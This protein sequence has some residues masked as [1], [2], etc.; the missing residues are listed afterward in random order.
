MC[1]STYFQSFDQ[2]KRVYKEVEKVKRKVNID[3]LVGIEARN[4]KELEILASMRRKFDILLVRGGDLRLN[5]LAC[6]TPEVDILTHPELK[7][8][9][10]GLN[11]VLVKFAAKNKVAIEI[12]FREILITSKRTRAKLIS[13]IANNVRL[14]KK[15]GAPL[16]VCSGAIS[17]HELRDPMI[18]SSFTILFGLDIK[19]AKECISTVPYNIVKKVRKRLSEN[20]IMPGVEI[21]KKIK[22]KG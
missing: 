13:N 12:N 21:V 8:N 17:H 16:I 11:H 2:I 14:A 4:R 10:S 20:W 6:E 5:R 7:R 15:Y 3:I 22:G 19:E 1:F 18:L 9:D